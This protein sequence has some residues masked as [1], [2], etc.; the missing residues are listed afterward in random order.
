MGGALPGGAGENARARGGLAPE[1]PALSRRL[2]L[3]E[4]CLE[5]RA[6]SVRAAGVGPGLD[7]SRPEPLAAVCAVPVSHALGAGFSA[8][9]VCRRV[10]VVAIAAHM[11]VRATSGAFVPE[12]DALTRG[13]FGG[14]AALKAPHTGRLLQVLGARNR[15]P[16]RSVVRRGSR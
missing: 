11:E 13:D 6:R 9:V 5:V 14:L 12:P 3:L 4:Q 2:G 10:V 8:F 15:S 1:L 16:R 7:R